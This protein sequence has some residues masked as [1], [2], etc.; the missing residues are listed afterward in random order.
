MSKKVIIGIL[1][2]VIIAAVVGYFAYSAS[3]YKVKEADLNAALGKFVASEA[4]EDEYKVSA[5]KNV[6]T[7]TTEYGDFNVNYDLKGNPTF[8]YEFDVQ[9]GMSYEDY[10]KY[11]ENLTLPMLG[12][13]AVAN[14]QGTDVEDASAYFAMSFFEGMMNN[15]SFD[16]IFVV[17]DEDADAYGETSDEIIL[18]SEFGD[19]VIDYVKKVHPENLTINDSNEYNTYSLVME[20]KDISDTS[21]KLVSTLTVNLEG[22]FSKINGY[23]E[24]MA[25]DNMDENITKENA[26]FVIDLKVGQKCKFV[27]SSEI[28]GYEMSGVDCVEFNGEYTVMTATKKGVRNGCLYLGSDENEVSKSVYITVE[29]N[30]DNASLEDVTINL[31]EK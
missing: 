2:V 27:T 25:I 16:N 1:V 31:D 17:M 4:N 13:I 22:D 23:V 10:T 26:D 12:Y 14:V 18:A 20:R 28:S 24:Q 6:M 21:C 9:K 19:K 7:V 5:Q 11:N 15:A 3:L 29:E 8:T 30:S